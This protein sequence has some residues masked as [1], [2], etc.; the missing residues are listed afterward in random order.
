MGRTDTPGL[1]ANG[2]Y[3]V[4]P[5]DVFAPRQFHGQGFV[6]R[7]DGREVEVVQAFDGG[8]SGGASA[9]LHHALVAVDELQFRQP[10]QV[11]GMVHALG[12]ALR[13]HLPVLPEEAGQ[14]QFLQMV[15][16]Q[17]GGPAVHAT[18]LDN[19]VM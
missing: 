15:F 3:V 19:N 17:Q 18:L 1:V 14:L 13:G 6:H 4:L 2:D 7:G 10:E 16:Q 11:L 9:P 5:L 12:R 8:E